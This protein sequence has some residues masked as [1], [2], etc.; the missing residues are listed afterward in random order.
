MKKNKKRPILLLLIVILIVGAFVTF[1]IMQNKKV[2]GAANNIIKDNLVT[3]GNGL[4]ADTLSTGLDLD[5]PFSSKYYFKGDEVDNYIILDNICWQIINIAQNNSLKVMYLGSSS[6]NQCS[7]PINQ[8]EDLKDSLVWNSN[9]DNVWGNSSLKTDME[10]WALSNKIADKTTIDF[11][12][13]NTKISNATWYVGSVRFISQSLS[14]DI[15]QERTN[16]LV[17]DKSLLTYQGK[18]GMISAS[19]YLKVSCEMGAYDSTEECKE[20]NFLDRNESYWTLS[21]TADDNQNVWAVKK[22]GHFASVEAETEGYAIYPVIYLK[23]DIKITGKGSVSN[24][25]LVVN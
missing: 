16:K 14:T 2:T 15:E 21:A 1:Y 7:N 12:S 20:N 25:Y 9:K 5:K 19:D 24:P 13:S 3:N 8:I 22:D 11:T 4:Y 6:N 18:V 10:N 23:S 17:S